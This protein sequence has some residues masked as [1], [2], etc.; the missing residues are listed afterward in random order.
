MKTVFL[1]TAPIIY[2]LEGAPEFSDPVLHLLSDWIDMDVCFCSSVITLMELLVHPVREKNH[3]LQKQYRSLLINTISRPLFVIDEKIAET[4][5][6]YRAEKSWRVPDS[7]QISCAIINGC[8]VFFTNDR[9]LKSRD[10][11]IVTP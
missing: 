1:D 3:V 2:L 8:D 5:A 10:I 11:E 4:A 9:R 7:L 6:V